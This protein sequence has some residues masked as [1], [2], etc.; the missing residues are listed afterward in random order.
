MELIRV[1]LQR[2]GQTALISSSHIAGTSFLLDKIHKKGQEGKNKEI[3]KNKLRKK[4]FA[5]GRFSSNRVNN[6]LYVH[7]IVENLKHRE[8]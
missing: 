4:K 7:Y 5:V 6:S 1:T 3:G 2:L 8:T